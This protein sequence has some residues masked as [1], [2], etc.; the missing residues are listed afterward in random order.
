MCR[1]LTIS[2]NNFSINIRG[3]ANMKPES[4]KLCQVRTGMPGKDEGEEEEIQLQFQ[5][6]PSK[7]KV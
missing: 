1:R 2:N 7:L 6:L 4:G 5:S 3:P